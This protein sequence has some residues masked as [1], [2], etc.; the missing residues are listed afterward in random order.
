MRQFWEK[1]SKLWQNKKFINVKF[2]RKYIFG[3]SDLLMYVTFF[4]SILL[5]C[6]KLI[7]P[8]IG[9]WDLNLLTLFFNFNSEIGNKNLTYVM[10]HN[11]WCF[12][13]TKITMKYNSPI[14]LVLNF[15]GNSCFAILCS[16][17]FSRIKYL[18]LLVK[19][20]EN[21]KHFDYLVWCMG[22]L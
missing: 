20:L 13:T 6:W 17:N 11:L 21:I 16:K 3:I 8:F 14:L 9:Q 15:Y 5:F 10:N 4:L 19:L 7:E 12:K 2:Q 22:K 18:N 1:I